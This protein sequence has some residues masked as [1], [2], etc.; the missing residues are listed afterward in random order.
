MNWRRP[1][2]TLL[3]I[4][5]LL[6]GGVL[7]AACA[8]TSQTADQRGA[9]SEQPADARPLPVTSAATVEGGTVAVA[10]DVPLD[11]DMVAMLA[12][13]AEQVAARANRVVGEL[14]TPLDKAEEDQAEST[15]GSWATDA[16][17]T[18]MSKAT[19]RPIDVCFTNNGGLRRSIPAGP[20]TEGVLVELM[21][22]ENA[23]VILDVDGK[24][25]RALLS[26]V[27]ERGEPAS[28]LTY[29]RDAEH[30]PVEMKINGEPVDDGKRYSICT[31][32]YLYEGGGNFGME[33]IKT[34]TY[35]GMLSRDA[36]IAEFEDRQ[37]AGETIRVELDGRAREL[38]RGEGA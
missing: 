37:A 7:L 14:A 23:V 5:T 24:R 31:N 15:L 28:G 27:V 16:L 4:S 12:P 26:E 11:D 36:F 20:V 3:G 6:V 18:Q 17:R 30:K 21:P 1:S 8:T 22:F 34:V 9:A 2:R 13:L 35:T 32:D 25:A 38:K 10:E 29:V 33:D 19:G